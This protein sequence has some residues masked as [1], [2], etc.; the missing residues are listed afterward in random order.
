[1][2]VFTTGLRH[3]C[4]RLSLRLALIIGLTVTG[5]AI[6]VQAEPPDQ[7]Q[8]FGFWDFGFHDYVLNET[9]LLA[10]GHTWS[11]AADINEVLMTAR[12][13]D[14]T[15]PDSW[16]QQW[17][18]TA[19]RL[20]TV[21]EQSELEGHPVSA[22]QAYL[23][24]ATYY[25]LGLHRNH[26]P[27]SQQV[28]DAAL[29]QAEAFAR[30]L[31][32]S[33][34]PCK[35]VTIPYEETNLPGYFCRATRRDGDAPVVIFNSGRDVWA[36]DAKVVADQALM[37]GYHVLLFDGPGQGRALRVQG[38]PFRPDWEQVITPVVDFALRQQ[39]VDPQRLALWGESMG[40]YL[41]PR[42]AA[43][44]HRLRVAI[45]NPGVADWSAT[46]ESQIN[47]LFP[48]LLDLLEQ[49]PDAFNVRVQ[50]LMA[51]DSFARWGFSDEM[52]KHG[53]DT[54]A[55]LIEQQ[56]KYRLGDAVKQIKA[57]FLVVDAEAEDRGD[58]QQ[59]YQTLTGPKDYLLFTEAEGA[60]LHDQPGAKAIGSQRVFDWLDD[61][62]QGERS[63]HDGR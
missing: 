57:Q 17:H 55:A 35:A 40:G 3:R 62:L 59:L 30:Y 12:R 13:V 22:S 34:S 50:A 10:L 43:Y 5:P 51:A 7:E 38:L 49:D 1:M 56:R 48:G 24:A 32:L 31:A 11:Q 44:E 42:A 20:W 58:A 33:G 60:H 26:H 63:C 2:T 61:Q 37:R 41:V 39:G 8:A 23:R 15:D 14:E 16:T 4:A 27:G 29:H 18:A 9:V 36:E 47:T 6:G 54:P 21:G 25:R 53:V 52:W 28:A 45:A 19:D 46:T